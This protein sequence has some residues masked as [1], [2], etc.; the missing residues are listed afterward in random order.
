MRLDWAQP[1]IANGRGERVGGGLGVGIEV[2]AGEWGA[3]RLRGAIE[4]FS[5]RIRS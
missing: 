2:R 1:G 3:W 5:G 4:G